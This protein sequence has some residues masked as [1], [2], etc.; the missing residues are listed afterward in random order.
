M[1]LD[2]DKKQQLSSGWNNVLL[3]NIGDAGYTELYEYHW[4]KLQPIPF[5]S[6]EVTMQLSVCIPVCTCRKVIPRLKCNLFVGKPMCSRGRRTRR[7]RRKKKTEKRMK[8]RRK[9]MMLS[10][11]NQVLLYC[12][13]QKERKK[14]RKPTCDRK[15][16]FKTVFRRHCNW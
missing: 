4:A 2:A 11:I 12:I 9:M 13:R 16:V 7:A 15:C 5:C 8:R 1:A 6:P 14:E 10:R 3:G